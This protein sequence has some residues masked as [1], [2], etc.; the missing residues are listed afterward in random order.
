MTAI[1]DNLARIDAW[2]KEWARWMRRDH[3]EV[4]RSLGYPTRS[5]GFSTGGGSCV[6]AFE[7][8]VAAEDMG[9]IRDLDRC[10][11]LLDGQHY[12]ALI[13]HYVGGMLQHRGDP[14]VI[15]VE[16]ISM[17]GEMAKKFDID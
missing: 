15:L 4:T 11:G 10:I 14:A 3:K 8:M 1:P 12:A 17:V 9:S 16:S 2:I 5:A 7:T 13:N 6:D